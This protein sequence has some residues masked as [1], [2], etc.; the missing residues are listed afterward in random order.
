MNNDQVKFTIG[1]TLTTVGVAIAARQCIRTH[2]IEAA[3]RE[4]IKA[5]A[6]LD[7][8]A[9]HNATRIV[10]DRIVAEGSPIHSLGDVI[11]EINNE[12]KFQQIA[13]REDV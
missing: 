7:I 2:R 11:S 6:A 9:I 3:K 12:I 5:N 10:R 4:E 13:I 1:I 8:Q